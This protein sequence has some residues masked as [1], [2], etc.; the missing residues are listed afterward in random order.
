RS[1][2]DALATSR[3]GGT[4]TGLDTRA[5]AL[6]PQ[7]LSETVRE[8]RLEEVQLLT[9]RVEA[10]DLI[11]RQLTSILIAVGI[12]SAVLLVWV[13]GLV[14]HDER[15]RRQ[16]EQ[17]LQR[18]NEELDARVSARTAELHDAL[19]REQSLRRDAEANSRLKDE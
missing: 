12:V 18:T 17:L 3:R 10:S 11:S 2:I 8:L 7:S 15:H 16:A 13:F 19:D 6:V 14:L 4:S 1:E 9:T 5:E